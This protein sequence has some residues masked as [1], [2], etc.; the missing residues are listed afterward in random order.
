MAYTGPVSSPSSIFM[1]QT[2]VSRSPARMARSTGAA[3][4]HRGSSEKWRLT[5]GTWAS[6]RAGMILPKA[7]TTTNSTAA[8]VTSSMSWLTGMPN[9]IAACLTGLGVVC[10]PLPRRRSGRVTHRATSWPAPASAAQG[11]DRHLGGAE[12]RQS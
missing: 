9:S 12:E 6:R 4:R 2:P 8:P 5:M 3:P 10:L 11:R 1:R 7:T